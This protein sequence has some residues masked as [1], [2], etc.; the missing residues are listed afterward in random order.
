MLGLQTFQT[1]RL[2]GSTPLQKHHE[3]CFSTEPPV[4]MRKHLQLDQVPV[5]PPTDIARGAVH[6]P[7]TLILFLQEQ[8]FGKTQ[9]PSPLCFSPNERPAKDRC[10]APAHQPSV[11]V[12]NMLKKEQVSTILSDSDSS[13]NRDKCR[14]KATP[15]LGPHC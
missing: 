14:E 4:L 1:T 8:Q 11:L 3:G 6:K 2:Q 10:R 13:P 15:L 12:L 7:N 5:S 9:Q